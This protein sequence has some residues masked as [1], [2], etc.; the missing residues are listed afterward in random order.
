MNDPVSDPASDPVRDPDRDE[1]IY[2]APQYKLVWWRFRRN[3]LAVAG[4]VVLGF[5]YLLAAFC[6]FW[7]PHTQDHYRAV[8][9]YAPPQRIHVSFDGGVH[10]FVYGYKSRPDPETLLR[11]FTVDRSTRVPLRFFPRGETYQ[12]WGLFGTDRHFF[13]P[14]KPGDPMY[15][16]GADEQ[17][18]DLFSRLIY[19]SRISMSVGLVG[20]FLSLALGVLL[21]GISGYLGGITDNLIQRFIEFFMSIPTL[22]LWLGLAAAIPSGWGPITSYFAITIILSLMGWTGL[23]RVVRSRFFQIRSEDYVL[24]AELDGVRRMRIIRRHMLPAFTS[25]VIASLTLSIPGMILGE[26]ALS[27][28]GLGLQ[29]PVV[30]WGVLL[31]DAQNVRVLS[32]APW[33]LLSGAAVVVAVMALNFVGDGLRDA[34]DPYES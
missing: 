10:F 30:S 11:T 9:S 2:V 34:A 5:L 26:T 28:L 19:G 32:T 25:H 24:A 7:A 15:L 18:R 6:E 20:V 14:V 3:R 21:G 17:G 1:E 33:L 16:F 27:F 22:P 29:P 8:Y 23:A 31:N 13:G 12:L 4:L